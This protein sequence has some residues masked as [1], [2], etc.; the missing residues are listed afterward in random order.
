MCSQAITNVTAASQHRTQLLRTREAAVYICL[1]IN[2]A[3]RI[4]SLAARILVAKAAKRIVVLE[5][6][7]DIVHEGVATFASW[8]VLMLLQHHALGRLTIH[9]LEDESRRWRWNVA[10]QKFFTN[11]FSSLNR[12][13]GRGRGRLRGHEAAH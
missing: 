4:D 9:G 10:T 5:C 2:E 13:E 1:T 3:G 6:K 12:P 11:Q 8:I 7:A